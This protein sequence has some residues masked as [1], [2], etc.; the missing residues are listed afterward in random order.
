M[1]V[2][3][4]FPNANITNCY[5]NKINPKEIPEATLRYEPVRNKTKSPI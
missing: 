4:S 5:S 3:Y 2:N 1:N